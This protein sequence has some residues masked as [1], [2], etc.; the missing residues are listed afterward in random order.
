MERGGIKARDKD[1][2]T[3]ENA[4]REEKAEARTQGGTV[5]V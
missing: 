4:W 3:R 2:I 5:H 1:Q